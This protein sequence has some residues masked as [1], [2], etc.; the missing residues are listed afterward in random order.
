MRGAKKCTPKGSKITCKRDKDLF[1]RL[2]PDKGLP[3]FAQK[4]AIL[5]HQHAQLIS[6]SMN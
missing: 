1:L 4:P 2:K 6:F 5:N 3:V